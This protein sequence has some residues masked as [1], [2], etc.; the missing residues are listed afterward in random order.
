MNTVI[1]TGERICKVPWIV[2]HKESLDG[3]CMD[4]IVWVFEKLEVVVMSIPMS[5]ALP[6]TIT[7]VEEKITEALQRIQTDSYNDSSNQLQL[8]IS[9]NEDTG[10]QEV[11]FTGKNGFHQL[12]VSTSD[13]WE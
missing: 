9:T 7:S 10:E 8:R 12:I 11:Y 4:I 5:K 2:S 3:K 13:F 6:A 1:S